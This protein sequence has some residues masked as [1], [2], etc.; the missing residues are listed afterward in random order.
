MAHLVVDYIKNELTEYEKKTQKE[1]S[2]KILTFNSILD[3]IQQDIEDQVLQYKPK[4][5]GLE[6]NYREFYKVVKIHFDH[7]ASKGPVI[8]RKQKIA[9]II[10]KY[11]TPVTEYYMSKKTQN[12]KQ[13]KIKMAAYLKQRVACECETQVPRGNMSVHRK[14]KKHTA[15]MIRLGKSLAT[16]KEIA[17]YNQAEN[18]D[19]D[20]ETSAGEDDD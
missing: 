1:L 3:I 7:M 12:E 6:N 20:E 8:K 19:E 13:K 10:Q 14:T 2:N 9:E 4:I 18:D 11:L 16:K 5:H 17:D 15:N